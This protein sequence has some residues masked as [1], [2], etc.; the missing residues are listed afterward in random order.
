MNIN[1]ITEGDKKIAISIGGWN[2]TA[3]GAVCTSISMDSSSSEVETIPSFGGMIQK[4]SVSS[5][6]S[7]ELSFLIPP[8]NGQGEANII[9]EFFDKPV[10]IKNKTV[11]D[12]SIGE[13][14]FAVRNKIN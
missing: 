11:E 9:Q 13:L 7:L 6:V 1:S 2:L 10:S 4:R 14:L 3:K 8:I 5:P 12:C